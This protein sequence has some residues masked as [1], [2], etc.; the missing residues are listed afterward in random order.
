M[1]L[2]QQGQKSSFDN[3]LNANYDTSYNLGDINI[4]KSGN[5]FAPNNKITTTRIRMICVGPIMPAKNT[6][7]IFLYL[8]LLQRYEFIRECTTSRSINS[9]EKAKMIS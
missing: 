7:S 1:Y 5:F 6:F 2:T 3:F 4:I 9:S 8:K